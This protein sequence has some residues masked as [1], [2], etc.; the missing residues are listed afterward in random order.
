MEQLIRRARHIEVQVVGDGLGGVTHLWERE[1]T[2]QRRHQKLVEI[3]PAPGLPQKLRKRITTAALLLAQAVN[4]ASLGTFE[5]LVDAGRLEDDAPFF[6]IEANPRL[7]VEHT[8]TLLSS[9]R[10]HCRLRLRRCLLWL[11]RQEC[12]A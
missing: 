8:I 4:Y 10:V 6:F 9:K 2:L 5:F 12:P 3:A 11:L 1:C 7:Q